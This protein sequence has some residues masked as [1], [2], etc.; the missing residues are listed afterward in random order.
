M[1]DSEFFNKAAK[2]GYDYRTV[3]GTFPDKIGIHHKRLSQ[4]DHQ[5]VIFPDPSPI[6]LVNFDGTGGPITIRQHKATFEPVVGRD[7]EWD[8]VYLPIPGDSM[9]VTSSVIMAKMAR[10]QEHHPQD[11]EQR[12]DKPT[13]YRA[14]EAERKEEVN[15]CPDCYGFYV[16]L[17]KLQ[18]IYD[19]WFAP[20]CDYCDKLAKYHVHRSDWIGIL[21]V[22]RTGEG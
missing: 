6:T 13:I 20:Q 1:N 11:A 21:P 2:A 15:V 3:Y 4:F 9:N 17:R 12:P 16:P 7:I 14:I 5:Y 22:E 8:E 10:A 18:E 19:P